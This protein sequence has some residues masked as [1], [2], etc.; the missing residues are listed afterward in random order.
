[1]KK[2]EG[3]KETMKTVLDR[4]L[5]LIPDQPKYQGMIPGEKTVC[6]MPSNLLT[7]WTRVL[8]VNLNFNIN[9][10][11]DC[12]GKPSNNFNITPNVC[13]CQLSINVFMS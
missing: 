9:V 10:S 13:D 2:F 1:M 5:G 6:G 8:S 7:D 12:N 11:N 3:S 4:Y